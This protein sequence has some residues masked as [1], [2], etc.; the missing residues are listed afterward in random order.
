[1]AVPAAAVDAIVTIGRGSDTGKPFAAAG[2]DFRNV[3]EGLDVVDVGRLAE[4]A[5]LGR[6]GRTVTRHRPLAF[7]RL[8]QRRFL[9]GHVRIAGQGDLHVEGKITAQDVLAQETEI[10]GLLN[11]GAGT[12]NRLVVAVTDKDVAAVGV[13]SVSRNG[14][15]FHHRSRVAL[16]DAPVIESSRVTLLAVAQD[17]LV[18]IWVTSQE[19]PFDAGRESSAAA[20]TEARDSDFAEGI[21]PRHLG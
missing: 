6:E 16:Q 2:Y 15:A 4:Y 10:V 18:W 3:G 13:T 8:H 14:D 17:V 9:T 5:D 7:D 1:M 11:N 20:A 21:L 12:V 19:S